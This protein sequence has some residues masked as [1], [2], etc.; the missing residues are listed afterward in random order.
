MIAGSDMHHVFT[1][2]CDNPSPF[3]TRYDRQ[4]M[5]RPARTISSTRSSSRLLIVRSESAMPEPVARTR[6][7]H[8][9]QTRHFHVGP[10][11]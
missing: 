2:R 1:Y 11:K 9:A 4:R 7:F 6:H 5:Q 8:F 10:T 3:M